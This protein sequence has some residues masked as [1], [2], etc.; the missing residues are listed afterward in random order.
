MNVVSVFSAFVF[1]SLSQTPKAVPPLLEVILPTEEIWALLSQDQWCTG[2][3]RR[4]ADD[5]L[6]VVTTDCSNVNEAQLT[7]TIDSLFKTLAGGGDGG[8]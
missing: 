7:S 1:A 5:R 3:C 8:R 2:I 6:P 4:L